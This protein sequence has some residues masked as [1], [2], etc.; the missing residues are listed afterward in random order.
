[1][2]VKSALDLNPH[3]HIAELAATV[4]FYLDD[5][6]APRLRGKKTNGREQPETGCSALS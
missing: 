3:T 1:M 6:G 2:T 4:F 5:D